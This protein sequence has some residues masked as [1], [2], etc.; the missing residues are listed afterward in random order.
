MRFFKIISFFLAAIFILSGCETQT[1]TPPVTEVPVPS[2][3]QIP[4]EIFEEE[5]FE[6]RIPFDYE[7][8][9][10]PYNTLSKPNRFVC[11]LIY[12][13][14]VSLK[15]DY[16]YELDLVSDI[17]TEDNITWYIYINEGETFPS[18]KEFTAYDLRYSTQL[19]M[20]EG[21]YYAKSL[22]CISSIKVVDATCLRITLYYA[23]RYFPNLL[24]F[25][26]IS[27]E[28][29]DNP[30]YFP[31]IYYFSEDGTKLFCDIYSAAQE[32]DLV[33][34]ED[35]DLLTYEMK[36]GRYDCIY[37]TDPMDMGSAANGATLGMQSNRMVYLGMNSYYAFTYYADFR[38]AVAAAM[39]Y[40]RI[41][42]D[43]YKHFA[44]APKKLYNP[45]YYEMQ[46]VSQNSHN[47]MSA[48]LI[49]DDMGFDNR[50]SEGFRTNSRGKRISL[51]LIVCNES[52]VKV[53]LANAVAEMLGE[54]GI[55]VKV[56][57]LSYGSFMV[58][59]QNGNYDLYIAEMRLGA[60]MDFTKI[61]TPYE[62]QYSEFEYINYG[63][64]NSEKLYFSWLGFMSGTVTPSEFASVFEDITPFAPLC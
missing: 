39:D 7:E 9:I 44:S 5:L 15:A 27:Y 63:V 57:P 18:G 38:W 33:P 29:I 11:E 56:V 32:I 12:R 34:A 6:F 47:L 19:A 14:M 49:L 55:E 36:M 25:P 42:S 10:S 21:S 53:N 48:N 31:D 22:E 2:E 45:D 24:T 54:A 43:V 23:N 52:T 61:L 62:Y 4:E 50:D 46:Y 64:P 28:T 60:D 59:L 17:Y 37:V 13:A 41:V 40:E 26:V 58:D 35:M 30:L 8:G 20:K 16:S 3:N 1:V 51:K